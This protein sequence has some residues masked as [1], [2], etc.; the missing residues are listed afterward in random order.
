[1]L[2]FRYPILNRSEL[3]QSVWND[4]ELSDKMMEGTLESNSSLFPSDIY[5]LTSLHV[6]RLKSLMNNMNAM[7]MPGDFSI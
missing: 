5:P 3:E 1:M 6:E 7:M 4:Q 2:P